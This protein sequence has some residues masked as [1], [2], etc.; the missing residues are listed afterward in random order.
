M[1]TV[2][3]DN[4]MSKEKIL[5][6][7][8][9]WENSAKSAQIISIFLYIEYVKH[10][11]WFPNLTEHSRWWYNCLIGQLPILTTRQLFMANLDGIDQMWYEE[12]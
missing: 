10:F 11:V 9:K 1:R 3:T 7:G 6:I 2:F 8:V 12:K 5:I 4:R